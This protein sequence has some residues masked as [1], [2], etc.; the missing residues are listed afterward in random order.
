MTAPI[1]YRGYSSDGNLVT[2]VTAVNA[3]TYINPSEV[4]SAIDNLES[5]AEEQMNNICNALNN[6]APDADEAV[7]IQ[8]TKMTDTIEEI[9][10]TL[11]SLPSTLS[12]SLTEIYTQSV[13]VH[14]S[15][16]EDENSI[17]Y[18]KAA[19]TENVAKVY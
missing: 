14:D 17:A 18:T 11:K 5:V 3:D 6:V 15:K 13:S 9:C 1:T 2:T 12:D 10:T 16:Q 4:K 7:I 19:S 8:G